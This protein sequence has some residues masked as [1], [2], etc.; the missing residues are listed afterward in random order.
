MFNDIIEWFTGRDDRQHDKRRSG[1]FHLWWQ[2]D[3]NDPKN[4]RPGIGVEISPAGL[5]FIIPD[6]IPGA[7][8]NLVLRIREHTIPVRLKIAR[9]DHVPYQGKTWNRYAAE[10]LGIAA[11]HWDM[12]VRY[13]NDT[14][15]PVD[16]KP[17]AAKMDDAYRMLPLALQKKIVDMLVQRHKLEQ[18]KPGQTPL[19]KL[20]Y[21]GVVK[22]PGQKPAHRFNVHSRIKI[23]DEMMAYDTQFTISDD[24]EITVS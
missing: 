18:P 11:D 20:F 6:R 4:L 3:R 16:R 7:E 8:C 5:T 17:E 1:A 19:L 21:V 10:Y 24:G 13:V 23:N 12:I 22:R 9:A 2:P 14:P 15:E